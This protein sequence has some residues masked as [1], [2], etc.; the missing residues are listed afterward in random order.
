V[1]IPPWEPRGYFRI[2]RP[3]GPPTRPCP[4]PKL[5]PPEVEYFPEEKGSTPKTPRGFQKPKIRL[6][7]EG[8]PNRIDKPEDSEKGNHFSKW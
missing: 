6:G 1:E 7:K 8:E 2:F 4:G 3:R 5:G